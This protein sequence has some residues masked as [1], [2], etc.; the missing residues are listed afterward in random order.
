M[1]TRRQVQVFTRETIQKLRERLTS[2]AKSR[3]P[4]ATL[5]QKITRPQAIKV[6]RKEIRAVFERD[7]EVDDLLE[8]FKEQGL[9]IDAASF[10]EYWR[11]TKQKKT[12]AE[13]QGSSPTYASERTR[14]TRRVETSSLVGKENDGR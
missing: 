5:P 7:Y 10:R 8:I 1:S 2:L 9:E 4:N 13:T 14:P 11:Q 6:L 3:N 12:S